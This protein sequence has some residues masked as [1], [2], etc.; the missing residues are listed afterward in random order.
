M[1]ELKNECGWESLGDRRRK[2]KFILLKG[3]FECLIPSYLSDLIPDLNSKLNN[4][5]LLNSNNMRTI[6][7]RTNLY[8]K[9]SVVEEWN[10][11]PQDI[12]SLDSLPCFKRYLD[13]NRPYPNELVFIGQRR[14]QIL[15]T[16]LRNNCSSLKHHVY[17][18]NVVDSPNCVC[19]A[20]ETNAHFFFKCPL[21]ETIRNKFIGSISYHEITIDLQTFL[22]GNDFLTFQKN[23]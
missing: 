21:Y 7:C 13:I 12:R 18:R 11:I 3:L 5:N 9:K 17:L 22:F 20:I 1:D 19:G 14:F 6:A 4:Y 10:S 16:R 15:H 2:Q 8:E 23:E